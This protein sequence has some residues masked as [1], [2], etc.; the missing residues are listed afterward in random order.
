M[1]YKSLICLS[2]V[3]TIQT[4]N[5]AYTLENYHSQ[6]TISAMELQDTSDFSVIKAL[7]TYDDLLP[8]NNFQQLDDLA[9]LDVSLNKPLLSAEAFWSD[10]EL[11]IQKLEQDIENNQT[12]ESDS[13][14]G[15]FISNLSEF[16]LF[17]L[18]GA[19]YNSAPIQY[20]TGEP[21]KDAIL[22]G[23]AS[24]HFNNGDYNESN[25]I[26][27]MQYK[28]LTFASF[29]NSKNNRTRIVG[30]SRNIHSFDL[31]KG[32]ELD[33]GYKAGFVDAYRNVLPNI[34]NWAVGVVPV[35]GVSYK[36]FGADFWLL[37]ANGGSIAMSL[38]MNLI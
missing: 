31:F 30:L 19:I 32:I 38:R 36:K 34:N 12:F 3:C 1:L 13:P 9:V 35:V 24:K 33:L 16:P 6:D 10:E 18:T 25:N 4:N 2:L 29:K 17:K 23:M 8:T 27:G 5:F 37:P 11:R 14:F 22:L 20:I 7:G 28:G 15:E 26:T 21:A